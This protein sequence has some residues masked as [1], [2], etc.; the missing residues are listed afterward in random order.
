MN[1]L[2]ILIESK[3]KPKAI[4]DIVFW[5]NHLL[6]LVNDSRHDKNNKSGLYCSV[7]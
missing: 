2:N 3:S 1:S 6:D 7:R 4:A 5:R